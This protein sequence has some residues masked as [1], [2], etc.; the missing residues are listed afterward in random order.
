MDLEGP[1]FARL[2]EAAERAVRQ[3]VGAAEAPATATGTSFRKA[4][5]LSPK[6]GGVTSAPT[7]T[8]IAT[9]AATAPA[10]TGR[11]VA[12]RRRC[13]IEESDDDEMSA[14]AFLPEATK[15]GKVGEG[16]A[17]LPA[18]SLDPTPGGGLS[19]IHI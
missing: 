10:V 5:R 17:S 9:T 6:S 7:A 1:V 18:R 13:I 11:V 12:P 14:G 19:L 16:K 15:R 3:G 8:S 2:R 4:C